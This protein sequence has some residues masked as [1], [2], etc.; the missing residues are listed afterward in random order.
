VSGVYVL[1]RHTESR[2]VALLG[3]PLFA[4]EHRL[5]RFDVEEDER[6]LRLEV[7]TEDGSADVAAEIDW[8]ASFQPTPSFPTLAGAQRFFQECELGF[9]AGRPERVLETVQL[10][11][12]PARLES[13]R[14]RQVRAR[15]F[16]NEKVFPDSSVTVDAAF[17]MRSQPYEW[18]VV[19]EQP[20][21][22]EEP[23]LPQPA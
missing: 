23:L 16:E 15:F 12:V 21:I 19:R 17:A 14:L 5:A 13:V 7:R 18:V 1:R 9:T 22:L 2:L 3:S 8:G 4:G 10:R 20:E 11:P 6:H